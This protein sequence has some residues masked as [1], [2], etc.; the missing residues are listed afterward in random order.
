MYEGPLPLYMKLFF[1]H[2]WRD[3]GIPLA[4]EK[5]VIAY[6]QTPF[7]MLNPLKDNRL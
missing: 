6:W 4:K 5:N 2:G 7:F 1:S 3:K